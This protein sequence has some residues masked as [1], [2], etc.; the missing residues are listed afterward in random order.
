M[1][2]VDFYNGK[3]SECYSVYQGVRYWIVSNGQHPLAYVEA[4]KIDFSNITYYDEFECHGEVTFR[5]TKDFTIGGPEIVVGWDYAH[6]TLND[7]SAL[8]E[9][10]S[11]EDEKNLK[12]WSFEE[13]Q[14]E[15]F[16]FIDK[17]KTKEKENGTTDIS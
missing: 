6:F 5:G 7:Y 3:Y 12:R 17:Y 11:D 1:N 8:W 9:H 13:I 15:V 4:D 10:L 2:N 14:R 16:K